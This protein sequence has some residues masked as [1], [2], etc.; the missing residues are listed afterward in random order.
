MNLPNINELIAYRKRRE[1]ALGAVLS[2]HPDK[3]SI[4][5]EDGKRYSVEPKKVVLFTGITIPETLT[6]SEKKLKMRRWRRD[7]EEKKRFR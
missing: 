6:D 2:A 4:L 7:L 3:L 5:S 1:P